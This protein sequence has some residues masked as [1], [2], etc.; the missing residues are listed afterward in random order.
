MSRVCMIF[1]LCGGG[2][3]SD[4]VQEYL[5]QSSKRSPRVAGVAWYGR[6]K[7]HNVRV[8]TESDSTT[9]R[10][11]LAS[12]NGA[13]GVVAL[14]NNTPV[15]V[16]EPM[17][18]HLRTREVIL[19][20][21]GQI[22]DADNWRTAFVRQ[23]GVF[24][25]AFDSEILLHLVSGIITRAESEIAAELAKLRGDFT[26]IILEKHRMLGYRSFCAKKRLFLSKLRRALL[27]SS[28]DSKGGKSQTVFVKQLR[29]GELVSVNRKRRDCRSWLCNLET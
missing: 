8:M 24:H 11:H 2:S 22:A 15:G 4:I 3:V 13:P 25:T 9:S 26:A 27:L 10:T 18:A 6:G 5:N 17:V 20:M 1:G 19:V 14:Y 21:C 28:S 16:W 29:P 7:L 23:G 12:L